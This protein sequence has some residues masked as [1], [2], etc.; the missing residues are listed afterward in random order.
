[1]IKR[2]IALLLLAATL[3]SLSVCAF[4]DEVEFYE[5]YINV[6]HN[7]ET[8]KTKVLVDD[9]GTIYGGDYWIWYFGHY[10]VNETDTMLEY[11]YAGQENLARY[12]K[13]IFV[14]KKTG[15][16]QIC[17]YHGQNIFKLFLADCADYVR[18]YVQSQ[19]YSEALENYIK[20]KFKKEYDACVA[21]YKDLR[22]GFKVL[23]EGK[24]SN[25]ITYKNVL[26]A[27][28]EELL[29][30]L[31]TQVEIRD[32][33]LQIRNLTTTIW[34]AL[35]GFSMEGL[36]FKGEEE[37]FGEEV[38]TPLAW[39]TTTLVDWRFDRLDV[40]D[41]SGN[42]N[43]YKDIFTTYLTDNKTYLESFGG[44]DDIAAQRTKQ[45]DDF[46]QG[47][48]L[49]YNFFDGIH[50]A[51]DEL[52][53][54]NAL[55]SG[56]VFEAAEDSGLSVVG[57]VLTGVGIVTKYVSAY[58]NQVD[59]HREMLYVMY[60]T[61]FAAAAEG[62]EIAKRRNC[63]S[64]KAAIELHN[65]YGGKAGDL[66]DAMFEELKNEFDKKFIKDIVLYELKPAVVLYDATVGIMKALGDYEDLENM[67]HA[68]KVDK[69]CKTAVDCFDF[70]ASNNRYSRGDLN[71]LRLMGI[72]AT[73]SSR[74]A[75]QT[76][77]Y[78]QTEEIEAL[79]AH[80]VEFYLA[81][82]SVPFC[83]EDYVEK[84]SEAIKSN[85]RNLP[86]LEEENGVGIQK[87]HYEMYEFI[88]MS[89]DRV[90]AYSWESFEYKYDAENRSVKIG[91]KY[92]ASYLEM[93]A[94]KTGGWSDDDLTAEFD[95]SKFMIDYVTVP[96]SAPEGAY[97]A[98]G[99]RKGMTFDE[100]VKLLEVADTK[101]KS[102]FHEHSVNNQVHKYGYIYPKDCYGYISYYA[103]PEDGYKIQTMTAGF[104]PWA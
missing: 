41:Q 82:E 78:W 53:Q 16:Y 35:Y 102:D 28:I 49:V 21:K 46:V 25:F 51:S 29:P 40:I 27:P 57:D 36:E 30:L 74:N 72:M 98:Y 96:E 31:G 2:A 5:D 38:T 58:A 90:M 95:P 81:A 33:T 32:K 100:M 104:D 48:N 12:A 63:P 94:N 6:C 99:I 55:I 8:G 37:L 42:I 43:D 69:I 79:E 44:K 14:N 84:T 65:L 4:A 11:Y 45:W 34:H 56:N 19:P 88:E 86:L 52:K 39:V 101:R 9:K 59:D 61:C 7:G 85:Y 13:R 15:E 10:K 67:A 70:A 50:S 91:A 103:Y 71:R 26:W 92:G 75:Y 73:L 77:A 76:Y 89:L 66:L 18:D 47:S 87:E 22:N 93:G 3:F 80:M 24:F 1:M 83:A 54:L 64:Y 20:K 17:V 68:K 23:E 97:M 62:S 60:D